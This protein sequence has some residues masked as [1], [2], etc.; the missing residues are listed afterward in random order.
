MSLHQYTTI[1]DVG[2]KQLNIHFV[3]SNYERLN[4]RTLKKANDDLGFT[5][6]NFW[7]NLHFI[8][9]PNPTCIII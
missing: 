1:A 4:P 3:V 7:H 9:L 5:Q 6:N 8:T 2:E